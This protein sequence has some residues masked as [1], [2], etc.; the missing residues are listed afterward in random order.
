MISGISVAVLGNS[1]MIIPKM[2]PTTTNRGTS[3]NAFS[4]LCLATPAAVYI[5]THTG[6]VIIPIPANATNTTY[7]CSIFIFID[8]AS[9]ANIGTV[10]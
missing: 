4:G 7:R 10:R 1:I 6:G 8:V 9:A 5:P 3:L 2:I